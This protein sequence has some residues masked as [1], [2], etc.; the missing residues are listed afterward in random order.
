M[1]LMVSIQLV[2]DVLKFQLVQDLSP[3]ACQQQSRL[4]R[5][6]FLRCDPDGR[7]PTGRQARDLR[8][9]HFQ[10]SLDAK[11]N[12]LAFAQE[13]AKEP[14]ASIF[15]IHQGAEELQGVPQPLTSETRSALRESQKAKW[16]A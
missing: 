3:A 8:H 5:S 1:A 14:G 11:S 13:G 12:E 16:M 6:L 10:A 7:P 9:Q 4:F 15:P 2:W